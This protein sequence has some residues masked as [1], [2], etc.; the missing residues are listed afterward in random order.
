LLEL[1]GG[2]PAQGDFIRHPRAWRSRM[3]LMTPLQWLKNFVLPPRVQRADLKRRSLLTAGAA[4][5]GAVLLVHTSAEGERHTYHAELIRPPGSTTE[6]EF[7]SKCIRCGECMKMCPTNAVQPAMSEGGIAALWTPVLK[8]KMGYC[9]YE[10]NLCSQVCPTHA[11]ELKTLEAKQAIR[12]GTAFFNKNRCLPYALAR[13]CIVCEEHC[14]TPRKA[15]W[16]EEVQVMTPTGAM[17]ALKQP[18]VNPDLCIGCGICENKCPITDERG[19]HVTSVGETRNP[20]NQAL[21]DGT[22]G[23]GGY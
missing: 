19:V 12:I 3:N 1:S 14:P 6:N 13:T 17:A 23:Y 21:L 9:E 7:L 18:R 2:V 22:L 15:I 8:M 16:F 4:G 11:I 5:V 10:C 20:K